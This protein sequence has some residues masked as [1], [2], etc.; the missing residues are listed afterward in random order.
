M[1]MP[2][3]PASNAII[4]VTYSV[5]LYE[6][7][8]SQL[9][10]MQWRWFLEANTCLRR[11]LGTGLAWRM[12]NMGK[13]DFLAGNGTQKGQKAQQLWRTMERRFSDTCDDL[14]SYGSLPWRREPSL[15]C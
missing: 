14:T 2:S 3:E 9:S 1:G 12:R 11:C 5:F 13:A 4:Y 8:L 15:T 10:D 7:L 6:N